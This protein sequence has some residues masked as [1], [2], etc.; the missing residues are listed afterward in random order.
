MAVHEAGERRVCNACSLEAY[1]AKALLTVL[2]N[3]KYRGIR[4]AHMLKY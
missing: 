3:E 1:V 2:S 4:R